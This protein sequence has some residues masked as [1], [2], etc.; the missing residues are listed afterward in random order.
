MPTHTPTAVSK[1]TPTPP[2]PPLSEDKEYLIENGAIAHPTT[3][4][5]NTYIITH[6]DIR[7]FVL[8]VD[9]QVPYD[10]GVGGWN[11]GVAFRV[12]LPGSPDA[13]K[14]VPYLWI[15]YHPDE[16][17]ACAFFTITDDFELVDF[18]GPPALLTSA[19]DWNTVA[20]AVAGDSA[21]LLVNG[22]DVPFASSYLDLTGQRPSGGLALAVAGD[23][24]PGF[25]TRFRNLKVVVPTPVPG[26]ASPTATPE[27]TSTPP[28]AGPTGTLNVGVALITPPN[29]L[30]SKIPWPGNLNIISWGVGEGLV[31]TDYAKP[32]LIGELNNSGIAPSWEVASDQSKITF[33]IREG[34][35][36]HDGWGELTAHDVAYSFNET[37]AEGSIWANFEVGDFMSDAV[38][39]DDRTFEFHFKVWNGAWFQWMYQNTG[40]VPMISEKAYNQLG[41]DEAVGTPIFT[42]PFSVDEWQDDVVLLSAVAPHWRRTPSV[43]NVKIIEIREVDTRLAAFKA[44]EIHLAQFPTSRL[45]ETAVVTGRTFHEIGNPTSKHVA[46]AGN[47]WIENDHNTGE[48][49]YPRPGLLADDDHPW[50]GDP[51][52]PENMERGRQIRRA[53]SRAIDR[54]LINEEVLLGLGS[55]QYTWFGFDQRAN[56]GYFKDEWIIPY[57]PEGAK[58]IIAEQGFPNGFKVPFFLPPDVPGVVSLEIGEAIAQMWRNIGLDVSIESTAYRARR[59]TMVDR[60]IDVVWMW[61]SNAA[62]GKIDDA[63][64]HGVIPSAGWN[65]GMEIQWVLDLWME[66]DATTDPEE[67]I[68]INIRGEDLNAHWHTVAPVVGVPSIWVASGEVETWRPYTEGSGYAG[69]F[70]SV[71]LSNR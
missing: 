15:D 56:P 21:A 63:H 30:P 55:P 13:G 50:I 23:T 40:A 22:A 34:I 69:T 3:Q 17:S 4:K 19:G 53:M 11:V 12:P 36:F 62:V 64:S 48:V 24:V 16:G 49:I 39:V 6:D 38:A 25:E 10:P 51:K 26:L 8:F 7:D 31:R 61:Q 59:P 57:D 20:L 46:F 60:S 44:G 66:A 14:D 54:D 37:Q 18:C 45:A 29:F 68:Q 71:V 42:G 33:T 52:N 28:P 65:R 5:P 70:E 35:E 1:P 58:Q 47:Y 27:L 2:V 9:F 67:R 41:Y 32:P 43:A